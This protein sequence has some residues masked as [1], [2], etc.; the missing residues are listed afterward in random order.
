MIK[1]LYKFSYTTGTIFLIVSMLMSFIPA[2]P[3][4]AQTGAG[5]IW[6]TIGSCGNPQDANQYQTGDDVYVHYHNFEA[7]ISFTWDIVGVSGGAHQ[8][9]TVADGGGTITYS[10]DN[11]T[12]GCFY[13]YTVGPEDDGTYK[14]TL[15][16][17]VG[18]AKSDNYIVEQ[19]PPT[20]SLNVSKSANPTTLE[21]PGG[22]VT[23]TVVV[24]NT[25]EVTVSFDSLTDN[26]FDIQP[27]CAIPGSLAPGGSFQ[28]QFTRNVTGNAGDSHT[29]TVTAV[30]SYNGASAQGSASATVNIVAPPSLSLDV[31][32]SAS[33]TSIQEPGG[34]V[35]YTV[36][37]TNTSNVAVQFDS[38]VDDRFNIQPE[39][40]IPATLAIGQ[41]F[42]CNFTRDFT[43]NAGDSHTNTVTAA[44]SYDGMSA[45]GQDS[46]TVTIVGQPVLGLNVTKSPSVGSVQEPGGDVTF[47][48]TV[49]NTSNVDVQLTSL[50]DTDFN[51]STQGNC[52]V[53]QTIA[54]S[55]SYSCEVTAFISSQ[56]ENTV[57]ATI[58]YEQQEL[59]D[60]ATATVN[61]TLRPAPS[62][63]VVKNANP[64][65]M[66]V[67]GGPVDFTVS[68]T[69]NS[70]FQVE[71]TSI[72]DSVFG[73]NPGTC[74]VG[75]IIAGGATYN[76][77]F[78]ENVSGDPGNPHNNTITFQVIDLLGK[79]DEDSDSATVEFTPLPTI[80]VTKSASPSIVSEYGEWTVFTIV[81]ENTSIESLTLTSLT[82]NVFGNLDGLGT[83]DLT[84]NPVISAG[85]SYQC[86]FTVFLQGEPS[87]PHSNT[88]DAVAVDSDG[89]QATDSDPETV[90]YRDELPLIT[91]T[92]TAFPTSIDEP[93]G[94]VD[95][96]VQV[97]NN[98]QESVTLDSLIDDVFGPLSGLGDCAVGGSIAADATY[99]CT[100]SGQVTGNAGDIHT[101][102]VEAIASDNEGNQASDSDSANV[103]ITNVPTLIA[104]TKTADPVEV[105]EPGGDVTFTVLVENL[106][107]EVITLTDL[108]DDQFG[109]LNGQ[110]TC[111]LPTDILGN[112]SY[113]CEFT[114]TVSG[115]AGFI[116]VNTVTGTATDN[117]PNSEPVSD[118]D[119][120][121]VTVTDVLPELLVTKTADP[122]VA[123]APMA[124][125]TYTVVVENL[126]SEDVT[127]DQLVD[128][129]FGDLNGAG[130]CVI[131]GIIPVGGSYSCSFEE[132]ISGASG[133]VHTNIV[134]ATVSDNEE[135]SAE[136]SDNA[137]VTFVDA[138][139]LVLVDPCTVGCDL[140]NVEGQICNGDFDND[141][142]GAI[143]WTAFVDDTEIGGGTV[144]GVA[145]GAC[146]P[147]TAPRQGDGLYSI[148]VTLVDENNRT[149]ET[150]CGPIS[151]QEE[152]KVTPTPIPPVNPPT[153]SSSVFIPVTGM[154]LGSG[155][156]VSL[157][158]MFQN[159]GLAFLSLGLIL[160]GFSLQEERK[161]KSDK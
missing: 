100:F 146:V 122:E 23:Y 95:F 29:N 157:V 27:E 47:T 65:V 98:A 128:D 86:S 59:T 45:Q 17:A 77:S 43:G 133:Y 116:H 19:I 35:T 22:P 120:A 73:T 10:Y 139:E 87:S 150:S 110:G 123:P 102:T 18:N 53:P 143:E 118:S 154:D 91:V 115:D 119:S 70:N 32:K 135:N 16:P 140:P 13:A 94:F 84:P 97:T 81:V 49:F 90:N 26:M 93:G 39:C 69:N 92:K 82:D 7:G 1:K 126:S 125:V 153:G 41:T 132:T 68:V 137:T 145:A 57:T 160:Q 101:N 64:S 89:N 20:L 31:V 74:A 107:F 37:V 99:S 3:S 124:A 40:A 51:L 106:T 105:P 12:R 28:C 46:A 66:D 83:C 80:T 63:T 21:E 151:C 2:V 136:G 52:S 11:G 114:G 142:T 158:S 130:D 85:A 113:S 148:V 67:P 62:I 50:S 71:I 78:T 111:S 149:L 79:T 24:T 8:G 159:I 117:D 147:L 55:G 134:T 88:V 76:C 34:P 48:I 155:L 6:T 4:M 72:V 109:D 144:N 14:V 108:V 30:I 9:V 44:I 138:P 131:G 127:L 36:S 38:L 5:A 96:T 121:Q 103:T 56:H 104:V 61:Y 58:Q 54:A 42:Q 129:I 141:Y 60:S 15:Y 33:P 112:D 156:M 161:R 75:E 152:P 25:S